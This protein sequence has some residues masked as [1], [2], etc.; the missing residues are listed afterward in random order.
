M[1]FIY[2]ITF[3]HKTYASESF[4]PLI[5]ATNIDAAVGKAKHWLTFVQK[6]KIERYRM[7]HIQNKGSVDVE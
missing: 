3:Q 2:E 5:I 7:G 1:K 4:E 6:A